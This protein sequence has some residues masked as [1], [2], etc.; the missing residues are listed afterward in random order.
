M[1]AACAA[2]PLALGPSALIAPLR[3]PLGGCSTATI[4]VS[5]SDGERPLASARVLAMGGEWITDTSGQ[6]AIEV[7]PGQIRVEVTAEGHVPTTVDI[8]AAPCAR[9]KAAIL[10][11]PLVFEEEVVVTATRTNRR[12]QDQPMRVEVIDR[13]DSSTPRISAMSGRRAG[14]RSSVPRAGRTAAGRSMRGR[15]SMGSS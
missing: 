8:D 3:S 10:L 5:V 6:V 14:T 1:W 4:D 15:R 12:L 7:V 2:A 13:E 9:V 11:E